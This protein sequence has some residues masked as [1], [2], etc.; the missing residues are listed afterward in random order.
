M[1]IRGYRIRLAARRHARRLGEPRGLHEPRPD[2]HAARRT[3]SAPRSA[4]TPL[5]NDTEVEVIVQEARLAELESV[6]VEVPPSVAASSRAFTH[7][8][9]SPVVNQRSGVS[10][11][12]G[13]C[14]LALT[15]FHLL[16]LSTTLNL[17]MIRMQYTFIIN[18]QNDQALGFTY[19]HRIGHSV[20]TNQARPQQLA[21][22]SGSGNEGI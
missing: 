15:R 19:V 11:P 20:K 7:T 16:K 8:R 4:P 14:S 22:N 10:V 13:S 9:R 6:Q 5:D 12:L 3:A 21:A 17:R 18:L 2:H 1:Q